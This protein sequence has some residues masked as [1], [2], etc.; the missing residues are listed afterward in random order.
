[1]NLLK[2]SLPLILLFLFAC[3]P[4]EELTLEVCGGSDGPPKV[5][6]IVLI[7]ASGSMSAAANVISNTAVAAIDSS[8]ANCNTDLRVSFLGVEGTFNGT[9]FDT[10]HRDYIELAQGGVVPLA[11]DVA[12]QGFLPELGAH[13]IEDLSRYAPWRN[14]ACRAIFYIS[15]EELDGIQPLGD[16]VNEDATVAQ[17]IA[18][19]QANEVTVFTNFINDQN[20]GQSIL[21]NYDDLTASTGGINSVVETDAEVTTQLYLSLFPQV[22]CNACK[23]CELR[24]VM[25]DN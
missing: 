8:L 1:M 21:D 20:R 11:S 6:L 25:N 17:A 15:D 3:E 22:I 24:Q 16:F 7:D 9:R 4:C 19:A 10:S 13:A 14:N 5:D 2:F 18:S 23:A 12:P